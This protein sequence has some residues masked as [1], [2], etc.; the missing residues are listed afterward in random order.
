MK[1][2]A[3]AP[4]FATMPFGKRRPM[5]LSALCGGLTTLLSSCAPSPP[6]VIP[7][8]APVA[9]PRRVRRRPH[10]PTHRLARHAPYPGAW[11]WS[12]SGG[13]SQA[14]YGVGGNTRIIMACRGG[15]GA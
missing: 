7:P 10:A 8:P 11:V 9:K 15:Q 14:Q 12:M 4:F 13:A 6:V 2:I 1:A 5:T 3:R